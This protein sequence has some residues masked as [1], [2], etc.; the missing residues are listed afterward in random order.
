MRLLKTPVKKKQLKGL[1]KGRVMNYTTPPTPIRQKRRK[2]LR[3]FL[4]NTFK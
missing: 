2:R 3:C 1:K 4:Y